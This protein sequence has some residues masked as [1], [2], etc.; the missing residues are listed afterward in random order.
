MHNFL[1]VLL[2]L[3]LFP[4]LLNAQSEGNYSFKYKKGLYYLVNPKGKKVKCEPFT[5]ASKFSEGLALVERDLKFGY[6]DSTGTIVIDY[7][8]YDAG[9]FTEG[10]AYASKNGKYGYINKSG[11]FII[12]PQ[13]D[14]A[15]PFKQEL[16]VVKQMN[17]DTTIYGS[18]KMIY[19]YINK[20]GKLIGNEFYSTIYKKYD[21]FVATKGDSIFHINKRGTRILYEPESLM[22]EGTTFFIV[23]E[24]PEFPGGELILRSY[25]AKKVHFPLSAQERTISSRVY[26]SFIVDYNGD[27]VDVVPA[28]PGPPIL[29][30]ETIRVVESLPRWKPG[31]QGDRPVKVSY[32][33]PMNY[34]FR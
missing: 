8:F 21:Y 18:S 13:F 28:M 5:F 6:V 19:T 20:E 25:I 17:P 26:V 27:V 29:L 9:P 11:Q 16:G 34:D 30:Q 32:T 7:Q 31:K 14:L 4:S 23:D 24:M 2:T 12:K 15:Y 3:L 10:I 22:D 1:K 33:I